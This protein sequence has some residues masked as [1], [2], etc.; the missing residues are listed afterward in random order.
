MSAIASHTVNTIVAATA[1]RRVEFRLAAAS[2][3]APRAQEKTDCKRDYCASDSAVR[4]TRCLDEV[5]L[6][7]TCCRAFQEYLK[8]RIFQAMRVRVLKH[9]EGV[10]DGV[11]LRCL[12]PGSIYDVN[13]T[14]GHFLVT[15]GLAEEFLPASDPALVIPLDTP[16]AIEQ[17]TRGITV[18]PPGGIVTLEKRRRTSARRKTTRSDRRRN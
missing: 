5:V 18:L 7:R 6:N 17:L 8:F 13:P 15:N 3:S 14:L 12:I 1:R 9:G 4:V 11:N 2:R 16:Y 10:V